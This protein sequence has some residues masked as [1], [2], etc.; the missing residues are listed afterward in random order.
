MAR[1]TQYD[2]E[3]QCAPEVGSALDPRAQMAECQERPFGRPVAVEEAPD[4][5]HAGLRS[6]CWAA[7]QRHTLRL[8]R[9][10]RT[11]TTLHRKRPS[12][13]AEARFTPQDFEFTN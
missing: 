5:G 9:P 11:R 13:G 6:E 8:Q 4:I 12:P 1:S 2:P 7:L 10:A 3:Q